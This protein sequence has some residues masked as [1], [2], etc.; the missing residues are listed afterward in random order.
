VH[1]DGR[2]VLLLEDTGGEPFACT[3]GFPLETA[4]FLRLAIAF[5]T[6]MGQMHESG[7][8]HKDISIAADQYFKREED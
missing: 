4:R 3:I 7:P 1:E 8:I 5:W 6:A 2:T